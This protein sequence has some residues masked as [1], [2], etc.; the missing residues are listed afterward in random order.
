MPCSKCKDAPGSHSFHHLGQTKE[1]Y[2][3][4][5][6]CPAKTTKFDGSD[7]N[8]VLYFDEHLRAIQG[9]PWI[10][11]FD[12]QGYKSEH[13]LSMHNLRSL[14]TY[15]YEKHDSLLQGSLVIHA[16]WAFSQMMQL[17][18]PFLKKETRKKIRVLPDN[19]LDMLVQFEGL[20][21]TSHQVSGFLKSS[22]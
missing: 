3:I 8:F 5:Y 13:M 16:G 21:F 6:T 2:E 11:V 12:C 18:K 1:G 7:P 17:V 20:G 19:P 22:S 4:I 14:V 9:K 10:W 15:L